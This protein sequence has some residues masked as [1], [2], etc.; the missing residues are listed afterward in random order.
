MS[1]PSIFSK[2]YERKMRKRKRI[3]V[4]ISIISVFVIG[5]VVFNTKIKNLD[6]TDLRANIQAWVDSGKTDEELEN[7]NTDIKED[8]DD[9][10]ETKPEIQEET[11]PEELIVEVNLSQG[12]TAKLKYAENNGMKEIQSV[13]APEGYQFNI[14]PQ[15]DK[16]VFIDAGQNMKI[17]GIDGTVTDITKTEYISQAGS[18]FPKDQ[19][20]AATPTY[21]WHSQPKFID[22]NKVI[23][24]SE[25]PYF[26]NSGQKKYVWIYD[27]TSNTH[28]TVWSFV[29][30]DIIIGDL[31]QDKGTTVVVDGITYYINSNEE[32]IQ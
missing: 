20:L 3:I 8:V 9:S 5:I 2:D 23:Y 32:I 6:F 30:T 15:K 21:T 24:V 22:D 18:T 29:G 17:A 26:G 4:L 12:I 27:V 10:E 7:Q 14:S 25:L 13:E 1:K 19:I 16:A 31:V 11:K 28:K